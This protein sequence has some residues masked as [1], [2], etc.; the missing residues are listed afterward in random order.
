M[1]RPVSP[2][3][4]AIGGLS[5][6]GKSSI[7]AALAGDLGLA[8]GARVL[9]S[10]VLRKR[11]FGLAPESRLPAAAY[12]PA[13]NTRVYDALERAA[14]LAIAAG[15]SVIIDAVAARPEERAAFADLAAKAG[16]G[17]TGLWLEAAPDL[18]RE[19]LRARKSDASDATEAVLERQLAYDLG[20]I[21][22]TRIDAGQSADSVVAAARRCLGLP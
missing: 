13:V 11:L 15:Y 10:D 3:L 9:R 17:F 7:A 16:I 5:G 20:P 12:E 8:P 19:R 14:A 6:T 2:R 21:T 18:L 1:L 22:W 4:V